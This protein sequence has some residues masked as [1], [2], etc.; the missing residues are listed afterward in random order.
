[1]E[2]DPSFQN[3][4]PSLWLPNFGTGIYYYVDKFYVGASVPRLL[5]LP[6]RERQ[7]SEESPKI[8]K[9]Y[10]H[11]YIT[12]GAAIPLKS[13]KW[14]LKPSILF[15]SVELLGNFNVEGRTLRPVG[16]P[17]ELDID[18]SVLYQEIFWVGLGFR[19]AVEP[20]I[21]PRFN[22]DNNRYD[23]VPVFT[24]DSAN[25]WTAFFLKNGLRIG[26]AYDYPLNRF[27]Q[28]SLG[29]FEVLLGYDFDYEVTGTT[30]PRYF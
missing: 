15:K 16:A 22:P 1:M 4:R 2:N 18:M 5:N 6:L 12:A 17:P 28:Y 7:P 27:Q 10:Q 13:D 20:T 14:V 29:S 26:F 25:I 24:Y 11:Y 8:A 9:T 3:S 30:S 21:A 19:T 23:A